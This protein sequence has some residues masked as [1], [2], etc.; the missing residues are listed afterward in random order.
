MH[1]GVQGTVDACHVHVCTFMLTPANTRGCCYSCAQTPP[2]HDRLAPGTTTLSLEHERQHVRAP[3]AR[4]HKHAHAHA[5]A[6]AHTGLSS[7]TMTLI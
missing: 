6:H 1:G 5:H 7:D 3:R 4:T 2:P